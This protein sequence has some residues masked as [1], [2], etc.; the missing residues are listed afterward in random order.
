MGGSTDSLCMQSWRRSRGPHNDAVV[1][2]MCVILTTDDLNVTVQ[3]HFRREYANDAPSLT[4][5][6][7]ETVPD[8]T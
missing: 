7:S 4:V 2:E 8:M 5:L 3:R 6:D 1:H